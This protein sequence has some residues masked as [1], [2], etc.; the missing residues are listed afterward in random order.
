M[1][2]RGISSSVSVQAPEH[3]PLIASP[4]VSTPMAMSGDW[5]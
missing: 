1:I 4:R 3:Q 5:L 2:G